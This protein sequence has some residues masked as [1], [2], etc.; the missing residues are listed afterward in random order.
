MNK[1]RRV[2]LVTTE[3]IHQG[4]DLVNEAKQ[5][6]AEVVVIPTNLRDKIVE[7]NKVR[8]FQ[9]FV[10]ERKDN[11]EYKFVAEQ[12][13]T[14]HEREIFNKKGIIFQIIGGKPWNI[15]SI[16]VSETMVKDPVTYMDADGLWESENRRIIIKCSILQNEQRY[17]GVLLHEIAHATSGSADATRPF[18]KN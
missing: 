2:V 1:H 11:F 9:Q 17:F 14:S 18:E 3:E 16:V 12:N 4:T 13:L 5:G 10:Q 15:Q 6:G 7:E 8:I